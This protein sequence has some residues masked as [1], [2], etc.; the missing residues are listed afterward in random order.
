MV[1]PN[2]LLI[3]SRGMAVMATAAVTTGLVSP[4]VVAVVSVTTTVRM[5]MPTM[6]VGA[7]RTAIGGAPALAVTVSWHADGKH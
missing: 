4:G 7:D 3:P 6:A 1:A 2:A 5:T